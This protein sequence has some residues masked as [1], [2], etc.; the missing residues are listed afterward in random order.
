MPLIVTIQVRAHIREGWSRTQDSFV[1]WWCI[2]QSWQGRS[3]NR[4]SL[5]HQIHRSRQLSSAVMLPHA[6]RSISASPDRAP[7]NSPAKVLAAARLAT[8]A[9]QPLPQDQH[10]SLATAVAADPRHT[11][12]AVPDAGAAV[13]KPRVKRK[14][15]TTASAIPDK[16]QHIQAVQKRHLIGSDQQL[17]KL[18]AQQKK[19]S[20]PHV[21]EPAAEP[22][23]LL[24]SALAAG[25]RPAESGSTAAEQQLQGQGQTALSNGNASHKAG[26]ANVKQ[27]LNGVRPSLATW[28]DVEPD[29][30]KQAALLN[31]Q[32]FLNLIATLRHLQC[33]VY[34]MWTQLDHR[35]GTLSAL[36]GSCET[37][38]SKVSSH[39]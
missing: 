23:E 9:Q 14:L 12:A 37:C 13:A 34:L 7:T 33:Y 30:A 27:F 15:L 26:A 18:L 32:D 11:D 29:L 2:L 8:E 21:P 36:L 19:G 5:H 10:S 3:W 22:V 1:N 38:A 20:V 31:R 39:L 28:E 4:L 6:R 35:K 25:I 16:V 17:P 24:G